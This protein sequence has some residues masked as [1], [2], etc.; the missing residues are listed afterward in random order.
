MNLTF[1][2]EPEL[3]FGAGRH[4]DIRF[5]LA[6][7][8]PLDHDS[9]DA[10]RRIKVGLV[11]TSETVEGAQ[12][13]LERCRE[14]IAGKAGRQPNLF[15]AFPGCNPDAGLRTELIMAPRLQRSIPQRA[16]DALKQ[17]TDANAVVTGAVEL[18]LAELAHLAEQAQPDVMICAVPLA[19]LEAVEA[20]AARG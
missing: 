15:P 14:P 6:N 12:R 20:H 16:F 10:P 1:L 18:F 9:P 3:E 19:L 13:W 2:P 17:H 11:G 4:V 5:G 8:G 7:Y